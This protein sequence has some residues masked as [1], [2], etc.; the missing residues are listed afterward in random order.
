MTDNLRVRAVAA[1][2]VGIAAA[3]AVTGAS[4]ADAG[5]T[6]RGGYELALSTPF[7]ATTT[8]LSFHVLYKHPDDPEAKPPPVTGAVFELPRGLRIDDGAVPRCEASD[9]ELRLRGRDACPRESRV[10]G[11]TL[12]AITGFPAVDPVVTDVV[13]FNGPGQIIE[14]VFFEGTNVVAGFDRLTIEGDRLVAHPPATPGGPP[15]GRTSVREIRI[16]L[17]AR[18][19]SDGRA[20]VTSPP[21]CETG[22]WTSHAHYEF[23]D[24]GKTTVTSTSRCRQPMTE[25]RPAIGVAVKPRRVRAKQRRAFRIAARS[26]DRRCVRRALVRFAG[27]VTRTN[28]RGRARVVARFARPGRKRVLV[29]KRGCRSGRATVRVL[30]RR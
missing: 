8:G 21:E 23:A 13:A 5:E 29:S 12:T 27:R 9:E 30:A 24:G 2:A 18:V 3:A 15:D 26:A 7:P 20:Y 14:V 6:D 25:R 22:D 28:A 11:G 17:P 19:G 10:G 16:E 4:A 1:A